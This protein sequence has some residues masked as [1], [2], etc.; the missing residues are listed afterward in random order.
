MKIPKDSYTMQLMS[1]DARINWDQLRSLSIGLTISFPFIRK[2]Q[3]NLDQYSSCSSICNINTMFRRSHVVFNDHGNEIE[4]PHDC[5]SKYI[6]FD[7]I[8]QD[9]RIYNRFK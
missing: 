9:N 8:S 2:M 3:T 1:W 5:K 6:N 7:N 4:I